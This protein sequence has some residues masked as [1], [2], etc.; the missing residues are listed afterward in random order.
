MRIS[1]NYIIYCTHMK[2]SSAILTKPGFMC[3]N[4]TGKSMWTERDIVHVINSFLR[5]DSAA[6]KTLTARQG[7]CLCPLLLCW[8]H[9]NRPEA[10]STLY[11]CIQISS[12][13]TYMTCT[14]HS[15]AM[16]NANQK[17]HCCS[18]RTMGGGEYRPTCK[19]WPLFLSEQQWDTVTGQMKVIVGDNSSVTHVEIQ[20]IDSF[21]MV[22]DYN[23]TKERH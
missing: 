9:M 4:F 8:L 13:T 12:G 6:R 19:V 3:L 18:Q 15:F 10:T 5:G 14:F 22:K 11:T 21:N 2:D 20:Q 23:R 1:K 17:W 16:G 7:L